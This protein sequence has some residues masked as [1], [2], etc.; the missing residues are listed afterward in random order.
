MGLSLIVGQLPDFARDGAAVYLAGASDAALTDAARA[1]LIEAWEAA[2]EQIV[3]HF[4]SLNDASLV[5]FLD[6]AAKL[7]GLRDSSEF[8]TRSRWRHLPYWL[9]SYWLPVRSETTYGDP[10]AFFGSA[11]SLLANL[12]DI[13]TA[14]PHDLGAVPAHFELMRTDPQ[15][16]YRLKLDAFDDKTTMQWLWRSYFEAATLSVERNLPLLLG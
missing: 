7:E 3:A 6:H 11:H 1:G 15:A 4:D 16:F 2:P 10:P 12:A 14:S 5:A 9:E 13:R 8:L